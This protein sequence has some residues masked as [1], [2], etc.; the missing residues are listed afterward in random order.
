MRDTHFS[1]TDYVL[2]KTKRQKYIPL[3]HLDYSGISDALGGGGTWQP[4]AQTLKFEMIN[5]DL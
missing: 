1:G 3:A 4:Y 5:E 2:L